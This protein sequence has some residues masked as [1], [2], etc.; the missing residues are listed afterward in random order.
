MDEQSEAGVGGLLR[1]ARLRLGLTQH[2][3]AARAGIGVGTVRDLEQG[4]SSHPRARSVQALAD[5]LGLS[6]PHRAQLQQLAQRRRPPAGPAIGPVHISVLGPLTVTRDAQPLPIGSGRHRIVL[7]RLALT[8][9]RPV[10]REELTALLWGDEPPPSAANVLQTHVSRL[11]RLLEPKGDPD[12]PRMLTLGPGGYRLRADDDQLDLVAYRSRLAQARSATLDPHRAFDL[13]GDALERWHGDQAAEDVSELDGDP[14][15]TALADERVEAT[16]RL[17]RLGETLRRHSQVLPLLRRLAARHPWHES[18][19]ARLVVALA[20]S[21]QQAAA[22]EAY[23]GVRRRLADELGIDPGAELIEARQSVLQGQRAPRDQV[24]AGTGRARPWQAPAPPLDFSGRG[25][26]L[27]R[28]ERLLRYPPHDAGTPPTVVCVISGM[29]GV[30]KTSLALQVARSVRPDFPDGQIY[31]DLR[32]ADQRPV[33]V[34]YALAR[35]LRALG[36]DGRGIPDD[37][38]EAA[39]LYR[40]VLSD[41]RVLVILDNARNSAQVRPLLPGP[42]GSAV[43]VTS[44]NRCAELD[45]ASFV[46]LPVLDP[47]DAL[48][49]LGARIGTSRVRADPANARAL[50]EACGRLPVA[51]RVVASRLAV[52]PDWSLSDLLDRFADERSRL[53]QLS[54][55]D[56]AVM[57]S[58][59]LSHREL[60][61]LPA[62]VFR[63]AALIPG[64]SFSAAA[65]AALVPAD[66]LLVRRA[67]DTLVA[68]NLLQPGGTGR[69]RYHDLLRLY[70]VRSSGPEQ[71]AADRSA[72]IGRL[73]TWYLARTAAA[74]RLVYAEMVRLPVDV[75]VDPS[76]FPDVDAAMAWLNEELENLVAAIETAAA[77]AHRARSWQLADQL[78]GYFFVRRDAVPWLAGGQVGLAAAEA[79]GDHRAQAAMHQT[80]GQ[81]HWAVGRPESAS[82]SYRRGIAAAR[83]SGWQVGE[84][85]LMHNLGLVHAELGRLDE[86]EALYQRALRIGAGPE[87][88]HVRAVT[89]NDLGAMCHERGQLTEAVGYFQA[90]LEINQGAARRPSAIANRANLGMV[91][92]QLEDIDTARGH[93]DAALTYYRATG[94]A[95]GQMSIL[96]ELSQLYRQLGEWLP[97]VGTAEEALRIAQDLDD[98]RSAAA[99]RNTLGFALLGTRAVTDAQARFTES[100][101]AS[102][103]YGYRYFEAQAGIGLAEAMLLS[104]AAEQAYATARSACEIAAGKAYRALHGDALIV[105]ARAA[106]AMGDRPAAAGHARAARELLA[107]AHLPGRVRECDAVLARIE[108]GTVVTG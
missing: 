20:A 24:S 10:G 70:A 99:V 36:V 62:R 7:A 37:R 84:A 102:R 40:S 56:L 86:A 43:L 77:G 53:E 12:R 59:E 100:L 51:L 98:R 21:G 50:V 94:S 74:M 15:V 5:V 92:R 93:L 103:Q 38:A 69:Y 52:R 4:R 91:L 14:L 42:G 72:A 79:A 16:I 19:H 76:L 32:G 105:L 97:A 33:D 58:F 64:P 80:I 78:R 87:F 29:A 107:A 95:T 65:V 44:R 85:Y 63:A 89:L 55:G 71:S 88:D 96:D 18:L 106:L 61:Q 6:R 75:D 108:V 83:R 34:T 17:A 57:T 47:E 45:G 90:A 81:A 2:E 48:G 60:D 26:E 68:E 30:G 9:D 66:E 23:D 46:D 67:L 41:R 27:H 28:V 31:L 49:M 39:A 3:L 54:I 8:P 73:L 1:D 82:E 25:A 101:R 104:G 13:L 11:R 35:L 22:L